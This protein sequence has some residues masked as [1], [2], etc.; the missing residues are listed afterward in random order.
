MRAMNPTAVRAV[1]VTDLMGMDAEQVQE[2]IL[3]N[4]RNGTVPQ[5]TEIP[6]ADTPEMDTET[7]FRSQ[8]EDGLILILHQSTVPL[9]MDKFPKVLG[10]MSATKILQ[11]VQKICKREGWS[12]E[13]PNIMAVLNNLDMEMA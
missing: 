3:L 12:M 11:Y 4:S 13:Y 10:K 6:E 8:T 2:A 9:P 7:I 5:W 1:K